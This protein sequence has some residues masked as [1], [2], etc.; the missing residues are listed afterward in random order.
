[1]RAFVT[2]G[3]GFLGANLIEQLVADGWQVTAMYRP[4]GNTDRP[5]ALGATPVQATLDNP[6]SL[7]AALPEELDAVF[8]IAGNTSMWRGGNAQQWQDNVVGSANLARVAR[9]HFAQ[10]TR[11]GRMIVTSSI[12]AYG[13]HRGVITEASPKL[14]THPRDHYHYSKLHAEL[15]VQEEIAQGLDAVFLNPCAIVGK[16]DVSS[17]AQT[18]F[19]LAENKLPGV[20]PGGGSFCHAGAVAR[21]HIEAFHRGRCGENY[22]LAGTDASFL[23][24]FRLIADL[25]GVPA[26]R[27]TTPAFAIHTVAAISDW[28]SRV[29]GREP[30]VTPQ[31][32]RMLTD[33][34]L[35]DCTRAQREL[36]YRNSV[37]LADMLTES[38]DWL[39]EEGLLTLPR[40]Q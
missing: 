28:V 35:A 7:R 18:F 9:A 5:Q 3:T 16:Y 37:A 33:R 15:A 27:R 32:A 26:P 38:R 36:G 24:F 13:Y 2:G 17:W 10:Q 8:H 23:E 12:S 20:P 1:M 31:K 11:P 34:A 40:S 21:A 25:V 6:E 19:L 22:I 39:V 14:A 30:A 29:S 4:G